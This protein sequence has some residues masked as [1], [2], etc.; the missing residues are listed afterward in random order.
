MYCNNCGAQIPDGSSFCSHCGNSTNSVTTKRQNDYQDR[1]VYREFTESDLPEKYRPLGAWAYFGYGLLFAI[2]IVGF[3]CL[4]VFSLSDTNI[5]RR[6]YA[7]S[8]WCVLV[9]ALIIAVI[10]S[11]SGIALFSSLNNSL[12]SSR[13]R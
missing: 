2:P 1:P 13:F 12:S 11:V 7:R 8:F 4:I 9:I 10:L 6:N 3:I 5:N